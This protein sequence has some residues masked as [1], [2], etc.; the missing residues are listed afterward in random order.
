MSFIIPA[1]GP[2]TILYELGLYAEFSHLDPQYT[3]LGLG[4]RDLAPPKPIRY[5][6]SQAKRMPQLLRMGRRLGL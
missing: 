2:G 6:R 3:V 1:C 4:L 5:R